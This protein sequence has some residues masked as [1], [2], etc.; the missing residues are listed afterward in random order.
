RLVCSKVKQRLGGR[1]RTPISG[2]AP[3]SK[4]V[5]EFFDALGIRILEGYGLTECTTAATV[6]RPSRY[7]F[8][9]VGP[10]L[11]GVELRVAEDGE[12][13]IRS[14]TVFAGYYK[15]PAA[16]A[17]VLAPDGWLRSGDLAALASDERVVG[18]IQEVVDAVNADRSRFEQIKRFAVLPRDFAMEAG[19]VT[20]T[21][22]LK[23]RIVQEHFADAIEQLYAS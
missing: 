23:R 15:D 5:A 1:L 20:P 22:K 21:L 10:A 14:E 6:N 19:E 7:R 3:L 18:L 12:L 2:G 17:A 8:G 9:T 4:E 13:L 16:T 11:P